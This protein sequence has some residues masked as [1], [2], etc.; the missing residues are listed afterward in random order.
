MDG[1]I[2]SNDPQVTVRQRLEEARS[3]Y[4]YTQLEIIGMLLEEKIS[5]DEA[6]RRTA[7]LRT[8]WKR[9]MEAIEKIGAS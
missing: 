1:I 9:E 3:H 5:P 6:R 2:I 4:S 7:K 8:W